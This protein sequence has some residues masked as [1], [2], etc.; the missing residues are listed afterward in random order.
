[1]MRSLSDEWHRF[2]ADPPGER[3]YNHYERARQGPKAVRVLQLVIGLV[4]L[5]AGI[6]MCFVPGPGVLVSI[7]GLALLSGQSQWLA[8]RLDRLEPAIRRLGRRVKQRWRH[9]A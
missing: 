7:F 4:L 8:R 6:V 3:F 2:R 5:A 1:M 9:A